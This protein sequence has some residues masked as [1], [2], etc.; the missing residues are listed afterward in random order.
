MTAR[1]VVDGVQKQR[2]LDITWQPISL[3]FKN[4]PDK[5]NTRFAWYERSHN[6][7]RV[8]ESIRVRE[9][10]KAVQN[11]YWE[12]GRRIHHDKN[13]MDFNL[14]DA[15]I[16]IGVSSNHVAAYENPTF[17]EEIRTRMSGGIELAGDDI[18]TPIIAFKDPSGKKVGIFG[19]VITRVLEED[20]SVKLWDSVVT[21]TTTPGFWELK[22]TRTEKPNFGERP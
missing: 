20:E 7:L 1:W 5:E 13:F 15:L 2:D 14:E 12:L 9:G 8:M 22:R 16:S 11:Y 4:E 6:L 21:L 10:N 17:D 19:P 3:Y 18:G